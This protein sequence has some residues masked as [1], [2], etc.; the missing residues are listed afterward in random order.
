MHTALRRLAAPAAVLG[1]LGVAALPAGAAGPSSDR[2]TITFSD[3]AASGLPVSGPLTGFRVTSR[4]RVTVPTRWE[5]RDTTA[6]RLRF[7]VARGGNCTYDLVY[8]VRSSIGPAGSA[9]ARV[10]DA[11][12]A[13][14]APYVLDSGVHGRRA[15]RVVRQKGSRRIRIDGQWSGVLTKRT[16]IVPSGKAAW[17]DIRVV[18]TTRKGDECHSGTW[19]ETMG[20]DI[21]DSLAVARTA[22]RFVRTSGG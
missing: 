7:K 2:D 9:E 21:G 19:R 8:T 14:G 11:L 5:R 22:L 6:G 12:P 15:F 1:T 17:T 18:A 13:A 10:T 16:D 4:A 20:P 3:P